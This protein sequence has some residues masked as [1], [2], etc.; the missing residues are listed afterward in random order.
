[1]MNNTDTQEFI[2]RKDFVNKC[3]NAIYN[4]YW[5][6]LKYKIMHY[7]PVILFKLVS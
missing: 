1:M 7:K 4:K 5:F 6:F 3:N 2:L